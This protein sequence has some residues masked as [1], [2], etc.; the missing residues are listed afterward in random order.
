VNAAAPLPRRIHCVGLGGGGLGPLAGLLAARGHEVSGSDASPTF[1]PEELLAR[2][3]AARNGHD[4]RHV[5]RAEL[6]VRSVAVPDDNP[7]V[8]EARRRALPVLKYSEALGRVMASR[9]GVAVAGTHGKTTTTA[10]VAHLLR[11]A[12]R[13]PGWIVGGRPLSLPDASGWGSGEH[14]VAEACEYDL[15]FLQLDYEIA[16][17]N[18]VAA[19]HLD[20]FGDE[21]GVQAAFRRFVARLPERGVLVLGRDVPA[22]LDWPLP[23]GAALWRAGHDLRLV[24]TCEDADG[25]AGRV[26]GPA[27]CAPFRL[28]LLGRHNLDNLLAALLAV[29][30]CGLPVEEAASHVESFRGVGRRLQDLGETGELRAPGV[31]RGVRIVDDFAHHPDALRAAAAALRARWPSRRLVA[32]FQPHQVS[33]TSDFLDAFAVELRAFDEALLCDIFVA[34]DREPQRAEELIEALLSRT[35]ATARRVGPARACDAAL[36]ARLRPDDVCVV[37]GAGDVDGLAA[38]LAGAS[39]GP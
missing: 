31:P 14:F 36:A 25:F 34:R 28:P 20:C 3:I 35:G 16:L 30:A 12:G 37:M 7:E 10:L 8:A 4:A 38:R 21:R 23:P 2:G 26:E 27:G 18:S 6:L 24:D 32:A 5:G 1:V 33:R 9:R 13:N 15:S 39:A 29:K 22:G 17:V 19:D 11:A